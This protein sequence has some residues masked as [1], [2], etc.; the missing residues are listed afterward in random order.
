MGD[1]MRLK[2]LLLRLLAN[3]IKYTD[4]GEI[5]IIVKLEKEPMNVTLPTPASSSS[6]HGGETTVLS[7]SVEDTGSGITTDLEHIFDPFPIN[8]RGLEEKDIGLGLSICKQLAR[9]F[10]ATLSVKSEIAKGTSF[11]LL[12]PFRIFNPLSA[13]TSPWGMIGATDLFG[14]SWAQGKRVL[15][16]DDNS[17]IGAVFHMHL[18]S[19]GC[20]VLCCM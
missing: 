1:Q 18:D 6:A 11:T 9:L 12:C 14:N 8:N 13:S 17:N 5:L 4:Q 2:V 3:A 19:T 7:I 16:I 15:V 10:G 20:E